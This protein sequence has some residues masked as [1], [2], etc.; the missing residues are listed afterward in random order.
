MMA[1]GAEP[2]R[3]EPRG[4]EQQREH[5]AGDDDDRAPQRE[6][7]APAVPYPADDVDELGAMVHVAAP[8]ILYAFE[9]ITPVRARQTYAA[10]QTQS[11]H[12][13]LQEFL[14]ARQAVRN[15]GFGGQQ[16]QA[17]QQQ[18]PPQAL[19]LLGLLARHL[20][21]PAPA[22]PPPAV[23]WPVTAATSSAG[24]SGVRS[25][26]A[27]SRLTA[28]ASRPAGRSPRPRGLRRRPARSARAALGASPAPTA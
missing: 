2:E 1:G 8:S 13:L 19:A 18:I 28:I 26:S 4:R 12:C 27:G 5:R 9:Q 25:D 17:G 6:P 10:R 16:Q 11:G 24:S 23:A 22:E 3:L 15:H 7:H 21:R 20:L 14:F